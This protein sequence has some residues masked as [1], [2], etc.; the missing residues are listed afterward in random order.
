ME[1]Q[2]REVYEPKCCL[3][4]HLINRLSIIVGSCD[5]VLERLDQLGCNDLGYRKRLGIIHQAAEACAEDLTI[6]ICPRG[7][8][9]RVA[10]SAPMQRD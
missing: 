4:H 5:L 2:N 9:S 1:R 6:Q 7:N 10:S 3:A 8:N